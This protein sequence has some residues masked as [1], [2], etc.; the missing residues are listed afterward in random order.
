MGRARGTGGPPIT[1]PAVGADD[2]CA[3]S[4]TSGTTSDPKGVMHS[5]NTILAE[6]KGQGPMLGPPPQVILSPY[7]SGH[8][9]GIISLIGPFVNGN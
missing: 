4:Y 8:I 2:V 6:L 7:P 3:L 5:A 9:G 1:P